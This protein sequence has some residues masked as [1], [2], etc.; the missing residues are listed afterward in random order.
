MHTPVCVD[1][2]VQSRENYSTNL[3][4]LGSIAIKLDPVARHT[5]II[6]CHYKRLPWETF[7]VGF[8]VGDSFVGWR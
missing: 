3:D 7:H 8:G 1:T 5:L 4:S 2:H 6:H